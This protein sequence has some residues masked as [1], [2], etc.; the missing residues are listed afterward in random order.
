MS[1]KENPQISLVGAGPGDVELIS[2]KGLNRLKKANVVL[3]DAL[4]NEELLTYAPT[5]R[6]IFVGKRKGFKAY[7]Q[8]QINQLMVDSANEFGHVVRLKGGDSFVFGRGMEEILFARQHRIPTE[9]IPGISS[10]ISVPALAEIPVTHRG[11]SNSFLVLSATLADGSLN[12][13]LKKATE[14]NA[15]VIIL[16]GITQLPKIVELYQTANKGQIP[17]SL[18]YN[19]SLETQQEVFGTIDTIIEQNEQ[20]SVSGPGVIVI[21]EV[22][23]LAGNY[24]EKVFSE[25]SSCC[26]S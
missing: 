9:V 22:V 5:A 14:L 23:S 7:E 18:V 11:I 3:Y 15:T 2:V 26:I 25:S 6:K 24:H 1:T 20:V 13:E 8:E 19:G 21:G 10:S 17:V 12:P 4:V 16:M